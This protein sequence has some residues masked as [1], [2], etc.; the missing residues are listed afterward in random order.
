MGELLQATAG[1]A[2]ESEWNRPQVGQ[3]PASA[4]SAYGKMAGAQKPA[5]LRCEAAAGDY[6]LPNPILNAAITQAPLTVS[7]LPSASRRP[8]SLH[9][10]RSHL[11][12][13]H[14]HSHQFV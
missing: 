6:T 1:A 8:L 10:H 9:L 5:T 14:R 7:G 13:R 4:A 12:R 11:W 2:A 3:R